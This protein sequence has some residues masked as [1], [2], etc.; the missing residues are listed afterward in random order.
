MIVE[1]GQET[2]E[3]EKEKPN[4]D[5]WNVLFARSEGLH[6]HG[7]SL[8]AC[9]LAVRLAH[10]LLANPPNLMIELPPVQTKGKRRKVNKNCLISCNL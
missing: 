3:T 8:E 9:A 10:E 5:P 2:E 4:E 1:I 7:H 6:A